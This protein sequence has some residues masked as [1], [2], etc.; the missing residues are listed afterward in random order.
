MHQ[1]KSF[2]HNLKAFDL[3]V[4]IFFICLTFINIIYNDRIELWL[5]FVFMN[6]GIIAFAFFLAFMEEKFP[7]KFWQIIHYWYIAPLIIVTFKELYYLIKPIRVQD[8]DYLFIK[9]DRWIFGTDPTHFLAQF[10]HPIIT[11]ILQI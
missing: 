7:N 11:E 10:S 2:L 8:Y 5:T 9:I 4:V 1:L 6:L 3:V